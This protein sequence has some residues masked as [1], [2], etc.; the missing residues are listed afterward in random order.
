MDVLEK[1]T[2]T[3]SDASGFQRVGSA[4]DFMD[5]VKT[6]FRPKLGNCFLKTHFDQNAEDGMVFLKFSIENHDGATNES[7]GNSK[8][9]FIISIDGFTPDGN[10]C[11]YS[12]GHCVESLKFKDEYGFAKK[13]RR[14]KFNDIE[15][16]KNYVFKYFENCVYNV[17][18]EI[19]I[20]TASGADSTANAGPSN[21]HANIAVNKS[22]L[23]K[24]VQRRNEKGDLKK[25]K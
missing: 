3:L 1:L 14:K 22:K 12:N 4:Y 9:N 6:K 2:N 25:L 10:V 18:E 20:G 19:G 7:L 8:L 5:L 21:T 17:K 16:A 23:I 11:P 13:L 15:M 24:K